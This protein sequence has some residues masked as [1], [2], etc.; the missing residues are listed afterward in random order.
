MRLG[1][2]SLIPRWERLET[3]ATVSRV[4]VELS[5]GNKRSPADGEVMVVADEIEIE[6]TVVSKS[7]LRLRIVTANLIV[8]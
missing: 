4:G 8:D 2:V 5:G 7:G 1:G 3:C 6:G